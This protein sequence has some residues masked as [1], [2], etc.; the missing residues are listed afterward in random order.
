MVTRSARV[1]HR[2]CVCDTDPS[3]GQGSPKFTKA[4]G[5]PRLTTCQHLELIYHCGELI[6]I[7]TLSRSDNRYLFDLRQ[8]LL[9]NG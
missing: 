3:S 2:L 6:D 7:T 5:D 4:R 1:K 9:Q 8:Q